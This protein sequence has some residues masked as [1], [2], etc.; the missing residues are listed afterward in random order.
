MKY[1]FSGTKNLWYENWNHLVCRRN[2]CEVDQPS[3]STKINLGKK[4]KWCSRWC[5]KFRR[6]LQK[7]ISGQDHFRI[8]GCLWTIHHRC[9]CKW[10]WTEMLTVSSPLIAKTILNRAWPSTNYEWFP[11]S[12]CNGCDMPAGSAGSVSFSGTCS[13]S[14]CWD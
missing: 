13:C 6:E 9:T 8:M 5:H 1:Y 14:N 3:K 11:W 12:I 2:K 4:Q 10:D 7:G